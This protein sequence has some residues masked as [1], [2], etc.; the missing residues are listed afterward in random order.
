LNFNSDSQ[1]IQETK[2][3]K[4]AP[5]DWMKAIW[6]MVGLVAIMVIARIWIFPM[7]F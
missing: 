7:F 1:A 3:N 4:N 5:H 6:I 2:M